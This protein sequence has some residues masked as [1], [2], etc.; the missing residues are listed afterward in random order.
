MIRHFGV[1]A[2]LFAFIVPALGQVDRPV[3]LLAPDGSLVVVERDAY[4]VPHVR[5]ESE[6][7]VFFGQGFAVAQDRLEQLDQFSRVATGR[8]SE[9]FSVLTLGVDRETR[10]RYYTEVEREQQFEAL[11]PELKDGL[12]AY[13]DGIN[14]YIDSMEAYPSRYKPRAFRN[15]TMERWTVTQTVAIMQFLMRQFGQF[16]GQEL[17]R[18]AELQA[19]GQE[20]FDANRPIN[21]PLAPTTIPATGRAQ[22]KAWGYSGARVRNQAIQAMN[23][24]RAAIRET[25]RS[26][27]IPL[28]FGSFAT[29]IAPEKSASGNALLLGAPQMGAPQRSEV[30]TTHEVELDCPTLHIGG[31]ALAGI[32]GVIIGRNGH[33]A[34]TMT[35]GISD[36]TDVYIET[37]RDST[38]SSYRHEDQ[39]LDFE[40]YQDS[41]ALLNGPAIPFTHYR[42]IHGPVVGSDLSNGQVFSERM[43]F[44]NRELD[45]ADTFY[46]VW[47]GRTMEEFAAAIL[48]SPMSFNAFYVGRD[49]SIAFW[50]VGAY[51]DRGDG[52][53][54]RL[55]HVGDGSEE[56]TGLIDS[57]NLPHIANPVQGYLVNWNNKPVDWWDNGDNIPWAGE[58]AFTYENL[59]QVPVQIQDRGTYQQAIEFTAEGVVND[60]SVSPP[61]QSGFVSLEGTP[62]PH[63]GD[64]WPLH[65]QGAF[66]DMIF[67]PLEPVAVEASA[68]VPVFR[69]E[70]LYPN[71]TSSVLSVAYA[72]GSTSPLRISIYD[73]LGRRIRNVTGGAARPGLYT[74]RVDISDLPGGVYTVVLGD[75]SG[76]RAVG[77]F[78]AQ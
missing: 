36:N 1:L 5:A 18:L 72:L 73:M 25:A 55:P 57:A 7:G 33:Y 19:N 44:W 35:S 12:R 68:D 61:G 15:R 47:K 56:W 70:S 29:L 27:D 6:V 26:L 78:V 10:T 58:S 46:D 71:P 67:G 17:D 45:M 34:W 20:W 64:Q 48:K 31:M 37:T 75:N 63:T 9:I 74:Q 16:G 38:F 49:Q 40:V 76:A 3:S 52:I 53:D 59:K 60:E 23:E 66:K 50:H 2:F 14:T 21:D 8:L 51:Q 77:R 42:T 41:V 28:T 4:G 43:T 39:W 13:S 69:L 30:S 62:S 32:P 65:L 22:A 24:R 11:R 54:P